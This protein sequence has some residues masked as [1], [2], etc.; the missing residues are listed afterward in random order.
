[1]F[2]F[3]T[4][5][6]FLVGLVVKHQCKEEVRKSHTLHA[7]NVKQ[8]F[9]GDVTM[10]GTKALIASGQKNRQAGRTKRKP[11]QKK[12]YENSGLV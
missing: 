9:A 7:I 5:F 10:N 11:E 2:G 8:N 12:R 3:L 4:F 6:L 1:M